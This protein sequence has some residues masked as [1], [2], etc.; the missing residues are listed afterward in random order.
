M[1]LCVLQNM[2]DGLSD[3]EAVDMLSETILKMLEMMKKYL[4]NTDSQVRACEAGCY[5]L[6]DADSRAR[7]TRAVALSP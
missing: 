4:M 7:R 5:T 3:E 6:P 1:V 2:V